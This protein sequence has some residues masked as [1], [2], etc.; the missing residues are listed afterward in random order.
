MRFYYFVDHLIRP[1]KKVQTNTRV[2]IKTLLRMLLFTNLYN[3][4]EDTAIEK[5]TQSLK[6]GE[7]ISEK[8]FN[9]TFDYVISSLIEVINMEKESFIVSQ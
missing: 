9:S 5:L 8:D 4:C 1:Q 6:R 7:D 3:D 2:S